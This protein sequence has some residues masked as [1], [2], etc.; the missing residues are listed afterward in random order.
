MS[1]VYPEHLQLLLETPRKRRRF[2][3]EAFPDNSWVVHKFG[4]TSVGS[5]DCMR[6]CVDIVRPVAKVS[7]VA[8]VVSAMGGKPKVTDLL[9]DIVHAAAECREEEIRNKMQEVHDKHQQCVNSILH[10]SPDVVDRIMQL[11]EKDLKDISDLLKAVQ[12]MR[13][14]H[15]QI[16]E[17]VSGYGEIWSA[18]IMAE[19]MR[20]EGL[21]FVFLNARE[22]LVVC[23]QETVGTK[24]LW[25]V[26]EKK[27]NEWISKEEEKFLKD[28]KGRFE[29]SSVKLPHLLITGYIAST[30]DGVATTLK[31]DGS[32]FSASIFGKMLQA[33]AITI[34][35]DVNGVYSADPRRVPEAQIIPVVSYNEAI[36]LAY[37]G[38]K[39]IHPKT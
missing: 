5:A 26:S 36:E 8:V 20:Q 34:W 38:A 29:D 35:T 4:G 28:N 19:V 27:L 23:E 18:N 13:V 16:L 9:L 7:R 21:P 15:E 22:V 10:Q 39:V 6:K 3:P 11:I 30:I 33:S 32:D 1:S 12:L 37:F 25:E 31:R 2:D 14:A 24:V 17:L